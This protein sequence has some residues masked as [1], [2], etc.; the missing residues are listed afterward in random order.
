MCL[1]S[2]VYSFLVCTFPVM[3]HTVF[4]L[5][6]LGT[7]KDVILWR[8]H[9]YIPIGLNISKGNELHHWN[10]D[11]TVYHSTL[12]RDVFKLISLKRDNAWDVLKLPSVWCMVTTAALYLHWNQ[13]YSWI[14]FKIIH[15]CTY[16]H[17]YFVPTES[18]EYT[19]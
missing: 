11:S 6:L 19:V 7:F 16:W 4:T 17:S 3:H 13:N 10:T 18:A 9:P 15:D 5:A 1:K 8:L 2:T 12:L 14:L